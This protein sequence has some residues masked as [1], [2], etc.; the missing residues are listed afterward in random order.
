MV[1]EKIK[2]ASQR[3]LKMRNITR[4]KEKI[5]FQTKKNWKRS[6]ELEENKY[7]KAS[8]YLLNE[9]NYSVTLNNRSM[10]HRLLIIMFF[11]KK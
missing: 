9:L 3:F 5:L 6:D 7:R 11:N 4:E 10:L 8:V 1:L 2:N